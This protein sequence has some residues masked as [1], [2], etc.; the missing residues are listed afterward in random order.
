MSDGMLDADRSTEYWYRLCILNEAV[1]TFVVSPTEENKF[2]FIASLGELRDTHHG[3]KY[4]SKL[5][6]KFDGIDNLIINLKSLSQ[7]SAS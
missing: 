6:K 4:V 2:A 3:Y 5:L 1:E 7:L